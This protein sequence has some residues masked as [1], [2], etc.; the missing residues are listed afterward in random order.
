M[1]VRMEAARCRPSRGWA[2]AMRLMAWRRRRLTALRARSIGSGGPAGSAGETVGGGQLRHQRVELLTGRGTGF[3][4]ALFLGLLDLLFQ[5]GDPALVVNA[6]GLVDDRLAPA[7]DRE[8]G[9][10]RL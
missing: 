8:P 1:P 6:G 7:L 3:S 9:L 2:R 5:L 4:A 10:G